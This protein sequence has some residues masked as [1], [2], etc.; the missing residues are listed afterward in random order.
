MKKKYY[1]ISIDVRMHDAY[2]RLY[3]IIFSTM[4]RSDQSNSIHIHLRTRSFYGYIKYVLKLFDKQIEESK[5]FM[6]GNN[7]QI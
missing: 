4:I 5:I 6:Y 1:N 3:K 7:H 2:Y